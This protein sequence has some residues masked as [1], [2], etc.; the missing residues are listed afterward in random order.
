[1]WRGWRRSGSTACAPFRGPASWCG[2]PAPARA[3]TGRRRP[4]GRAAGRGGAAGGGAAPE[5]RYLPVR[6]TTLHVEQSLAR[7]LAWAVL[8]PNGEPLWAQIRARVAAFLD[9]LY[10]AGA[11]H[12]RSAR[13]AYF[14]RCGRDTTPQADLDRGVVTVEVGFAAIKPAEFVVVRITQATAPPG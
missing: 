9:D 14:V 4:A 8:E 2:A 13:E 10:R 12:G 1:M 11:F 3:A 6:R 7:G 5:V